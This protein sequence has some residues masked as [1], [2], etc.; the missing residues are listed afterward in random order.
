MRLYL[1]SRKLANHYDLIGRDSRLSPMRQQLGRDPNQP[2]ELGLIAIGNLLHNFLVNL[3]I[4]AG[5]IS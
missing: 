2:G 3:C 1:P 4:H 5:N